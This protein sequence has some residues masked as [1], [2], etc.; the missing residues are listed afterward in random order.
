MGTHWYHAHF[1]G[2]SF[3]HVSGGM[4]GPLVVLP[5]A[6]YVL[7]SDLTLLYSSARLLHLQ[8]VHFGGGGDVDMEA[9][10]ATH[11]HASLSA[12]F[13]VQPVPPNVTFASDSTPRDFYVV[14]GQYQ[15]L[16]TI[17]PDDA[18]LL[19]SAA[20]HPFFVQVCDV[21]VCM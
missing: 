4:S 1:H 18:T 7:P 12:A 15:P 11:D 6:G 16:I 14:N 9:E 13:S 3:L 17:Q 20:V 21:V 8:H 19:V 10:F 2:S 5:G